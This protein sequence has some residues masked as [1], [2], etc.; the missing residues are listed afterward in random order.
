MSSQ[1]SIDKVWIWKF[2]SLNLKVWI[3]KFEFE[4]SSQRSIDKVWI[5]KFEFE[6]L[7]VWIWNEQPAEHWQGAAELK[8]SV[9]PIG[10]RAAFYPRVK[11]PPIEIWDAGGG[12]GGLTRLWITHTQQ[13]QKVA[14]KRQI[15]RKQIKWASKKRAS[16]RSNRW[17][18]KRLKGKVKSIKRR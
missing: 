5:L 3:W 4:M 18:R 10:G 9:R 8:C 11:N 7:K 17:K 16:E 2:E 13:H 12:G 15:C 6:S 1:R 14:A